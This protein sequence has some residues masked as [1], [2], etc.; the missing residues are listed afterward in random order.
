MFCTALF[1]LL[2][3]TCCTNKV[4]HYYYFLQVTWGVI[5][6]KQCLCIPVCFFRPYN[7]NRLISLLLYLFC[8]RTLCSWG[9]SA[10]EFRT[11][12]QEPETRVAVVIP[13][14]S[15]RCHVRWVYL[16]SPNEMGPKCGEKRAGGVMLCCVQVY[17]SLRKKEGCYC[18]YMPPKQIPFCLKVSLRTPWGKRVQ[19][20]MINSVTVKQKS[21]TYLSLLLDVSV[22]LRGLAAVFVAQTSNHPKPFN[23]MFTCYRCV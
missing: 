18:T 16:S 3:K 22:L 6:V 12:V 13:P 17:I 23:W 7:L 20:Q 1:K 9:T 5:S 14:Q 2:L 11:S 8:H 10:V 19:L 4:Y 21:R 15:T